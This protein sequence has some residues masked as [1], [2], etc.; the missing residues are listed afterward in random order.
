MNLEQS[1]IF[2]HKQVETLKEQKEVNETQVNFYQKF[3]C[4]LSELLR[5]R[6]FLSEF[7]NEIELSK[8]CNFSQEWLLDFI[9]EEVEDWRL[10]EIIE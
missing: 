8:E 7:T 6:L 2:I 9:H 1:I 4:W 3:E 10:N 5:Y